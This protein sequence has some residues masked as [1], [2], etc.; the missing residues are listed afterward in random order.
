MVT[1]FF[2]EYEN[3]DIDLKTPVFTVSRKNI[4]KGIE[5]LQ[6]DFQTI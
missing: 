3:F 1:V 5:I 4:Q 6:D 2:T